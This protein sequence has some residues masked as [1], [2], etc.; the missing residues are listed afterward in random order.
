VRAATAEE[1]L[2][3]AN[4][5]ELGRDKEFWPMVGFFSFVLL[6]SILFQFH[7]SILIRNFK[8]LCTIKIQ[9]VSEV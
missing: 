7:I 6:F 9:H 5:S 1:K 2:G 8:F 4:G 3:H